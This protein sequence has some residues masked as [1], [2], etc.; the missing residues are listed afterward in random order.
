MKNFVLTFSFLSIFI[1]SCN[2]SGVWKD[3]HIDPNIKAKIHEL[4]YQII[5]GFIA[6]NPDKVFPIC[7]DKLL[8]QGKSNL[9][10][11]IQQSKQDISFSKNNF[12]ILNEF[13]QKNS[14]SKAMT[15]VIS[16]FSGDHDYTI[17]YE[18][19][20]SEM[21]VTVGYFDKGLNQTSLTLIYGK[22]DKEW[23]L[24]V[25]LVGTL[26]MMNMDA[27]D[28]YN[29]GKSDYEK[30]YFIDAIN[31]LVIANKLLKPANE[32]FQ[33]HKE[34]EI[35]EFGQKVMTEINT[36]YTFPMTVD[37]VKT[38]PQIFGI[39]PQPLNEGYFPMIAYTTSID[40]HDTVSL[41]KECNEIH[42]KIGQL[43]HGIDKNKKWILYMA[44]KS[45]PSGNIPVENY[46]FKRE[47]K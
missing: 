22:S 13:Y 42:S 45:L 8:E 43:Y 46:G 41:S 32:F 30:G 44:F 12:K 16:G 17:N 31:D 35:Q 23:K 4:D 3:D 6:N 33:Y 39:S 5:D 2:L 34:K 37:Y 25:L 26:R 15:N 28:W 1:T 18:A 24:Y 10:I 20:N 29:L 19:Q 21:F 14:S 7:S 11:L 27:F 38:K 36:K 47:N 9:L 40:I